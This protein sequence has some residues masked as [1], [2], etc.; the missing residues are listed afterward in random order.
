[1]YITKHGLLTA[2]RMHYPCHFVPFIIILLLLLTLLL[3]KNSAARELLVI[4][5]ISVS[6]RPQPSSSC[7]VKNHRSNFWF[8]QQA[9]ERKLSNN[10]ERHLHF[11]RLQIVSIL[12]RIYDHFCTWP[13]RQAGRAAA[14]H[15]N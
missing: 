14:R 15:S 4:Y 8:S 5:R 7:C 10:M 13:G 2:A 12:T 1:M 3:W 6:D 9:V 11:Y